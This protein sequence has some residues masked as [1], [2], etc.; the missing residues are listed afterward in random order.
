[1]A[2][3]FYFFPCLFCKSVFIVFGFVY[4]FL[5]GNGNGNPRMKDSFKEETPLKKKHK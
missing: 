2:M 5:F 3:R 1:M 4:D